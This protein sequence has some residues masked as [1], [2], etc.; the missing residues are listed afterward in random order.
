MATRLMLRASSAPGARALSAQ[1]L[2]ARSIAAEPP[3]IQV[4]QLENGLTVASVDNGKPV[5]TLGVVIRAGPRN[6]THE[7]AGISHALRACAGLCSK[8]FSAFGITRNLQQIGST[9]VVTQGREH[10][11]YS[12]QMTKDH[13]DAGID[14]LLDAAG[15]QMF[16]PWEVAEAYDRMR[17]DL[18]DMPPAARVSELLHRAAFRDSGLGNSLYSPEHLIGSH[19]PGAL[20][21][22]AAAA[23]TP[24]QTALV[25][26]GLEHD[27]I[28]NYAAILDIGKG[29]SVVPAAAVFHGDELRQETGGKLAHVAVAGA[30]AGAANV[31]DAIANMILQRVLG[32]GARVKW[33]SGSSG[34]LHKVLSGV[35]LVAAAG[36]HNSYSDAGLVGA[37]I[38]ADA[39]QAGKAVA[40]TVAALRSLS[41]TEDEVAA[42]KKALQVD[43]AEAFEDPMQQAESFGAQA[44]MRAKWEPNQPD[45][46]SAVTVA[47][48]QAAAHTLAS[49]KLA[50]AAIGNLSSV[51]YLDSI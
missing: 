20:K 10:T 39:A 18:V 5:I 35:D 28:R 46:I 27:T 37:F 22:F 42:A 40:A 13:L 25:A 31:T 34:Q 49:G 21:S 15:G 23:L 50:L 32:M 1:A 30:T 17:V 45:K 44:L 6:E 16:K 38:A 43:L 24:A 9:L 12:S 4:S 19:G 41:V 7:N 36:I 3:P 2:Q 47:D 8:N 33:G 11:M 14:F 26:V 29:P 51:P 48:V